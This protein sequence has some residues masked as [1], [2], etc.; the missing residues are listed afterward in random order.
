MPPFKTSLCRAPGG[1]FTLPNFSGADIAASASATSVSQLLLMVALL[2]V[3]PAMLFWQYHRRRWWTMGVGMATFILML[4]YLMLKD[5]GSLWQT[6]AATTILCGPP[7]LALVWF[8]T[9][10]RTLGRAVSGSA[11]VALSL[12]DRAALAVLTVTAH[13]LFFIAATIADIASPA[14]LS[15][16]GD[17]VNCL[18]HLARPVDFRAQGDQLNML[19]TALPALGVATLLHGWLRRRRTV[20]SP[21]PMLRL[22]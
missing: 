19:L 21:I 2:S 4:D 14:L 5:R 15:V 7:Y 17:A 13:L 6:L 8:R 16:V 20:G 9:A 1:F 11:T 10:M 22:R 12:S 3:L 18:Y